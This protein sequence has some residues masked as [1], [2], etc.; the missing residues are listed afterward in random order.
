MNIAETPTY[1]LIILT[2]VGAYAGA[3]NVLAGGG[4]FITFPVLMLIGLDPLSANIT[5][6]V[7]LSPSQL[8]STIAGRK[9][10]AGIHETNFKQLFL[11]S[12]L[13][14]GIGASLLLATP[15]SLFV[16][17]V[18]GLILFAT[19]IFAWGSFRKSTEKHKH[20]P[21]YALLTIQGII[22]IY[23]GYFGG[24]IGFLLLAL[25]T[26]S[27]QTIKIASATKNA[28]A[29]TM[30]ISAVIIFC[31]SPLINWLAVIALGAGGIAGGFLGVKLTH[32]IPDKLLRSF[33]VAIGT[34]L[35]VWLFIR[36]T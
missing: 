32:R 36:S 9:L 24:G 13:G 6:T 35:T 31:F 33:I 1:S 29:F 22:S 12:L 30:N 27:G 20:I 3:Q 28:L 18:P 7:A 26:I 19:I 34:V 14:G 2:F 11:M 25:L 4:S 17:I 23:G 21:R 10:I 16:R 5:S 8:T 15:V